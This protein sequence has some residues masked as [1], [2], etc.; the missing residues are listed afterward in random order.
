MKEKA[1]E[2]QTLVEIIMERV[3][4]GEDGPTWQF[5]GVYL[6]VTVLQLCSP[7]NKFRLLFIY[8]PFCFVV[9]W[10]P[11]CTTIS[12]WMVEKMMKKIMM[13]QWLLMVVTILTKHGKILA[14]DVM[15][16]KIYDNLHFIWHIYAHM[17][18]NLHLSPGVCGLVSKQLMIRD[19]N[20]FGK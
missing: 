8:S 1:G 3:P 13:C 12:S 20:L 2:R 11:Q 19:K 10:L 18:R 16:E 5:H 15:N 7:D 4:F 17:L 9:H 6:G 14:S